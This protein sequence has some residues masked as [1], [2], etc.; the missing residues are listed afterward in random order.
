[1]AGGCGLVRRAEL[2][3]LGLARSMVDRLIRGQVL[4]PLANGVYADPGRLAGISSWDLHR[5]RTRAFL[6][7]SPPNTY[8]ADWSAIA[9]H[10]LPTIGDPPPVPSVI[11]PR[12]GRSGSNRTVHGRTRF[13]PVPDRWL[14]TIG[15]IPIIG[16]A[17]AAVDLGR[18]A[19]RLT[20]L[21]L[22]DAVAARHGG[23]EQLAGALGDIDGWSGERHAAWAV[24]HCDVDVESPLESA[25][26]LAFI[27][28][29][30]P[31]SRSN[32]WVG[33]YVPELRLDHYWPEYRVGAE[34][35]GLT[36]YAHNPALAIRN[37]KDREWR[38][39]R[40]GIRVIRYGWRVAVGSPDALA[41]QV[42]ELLNAPPLP[43]RGLRTWSNAQGRALLG[44]GP[45][46][47]ARA[48]T[49]TR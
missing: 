34:A 31:P 22:A 6:M 20:S 35:D 13:T 11:R 10:E 14:G 23:R 8:A 30:L 46:S 38:I 2:E 33:E 15:D 36:K 42:R 17:F 40:L 7:M 47:Y 28:A 9:L 19:D 16:A 3:R 25:G 1:M 18:R 5:L 39:Q 26:R 44:I 21:V 48:P 49:W 32:E 43:A 27:T 41:G 24:R 29:G 37:E 12:P 45:S 4:V